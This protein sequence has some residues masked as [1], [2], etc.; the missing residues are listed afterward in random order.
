MFVYQYVDIRL[1]DPST[2]DPLD[3]IYN[4]VCLETTG[5]RYRT[6]VP[7]SCLKKEEDRKKGEKGPLTSIGYLG[8]QVRIT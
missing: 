7:E 4:R 2:C 5:Q 3:M 8:S 6:L 1:D